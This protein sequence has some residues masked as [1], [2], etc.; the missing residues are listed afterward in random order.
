MV[1]ESMSGSVVA[2]RITF[3]IDYYYYRIEQFWLTNAFRKCPTK[4]HLQHFFAA[5]YCSYHYPVVGDTFV[6]C[7]NVHFSTAVIFE[8]MQ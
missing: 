5:N 6:F 1:S 3:A 8:S 7:Q 4:L 2:E